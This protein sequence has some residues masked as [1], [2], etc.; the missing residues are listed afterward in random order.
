VEVSRL[1]VL[2]QRFSDRY[3][4]GTYD[5]GVQSGGRIAYVRLLGAIGVII[6]LV[7]AFNF[8]SLSTAMASRRMREVGM[9]KV[10]GARRGMIVGQFIG[11]AVLLATM[12]LV[13]SVG[14]VAVVLPF[15]NTLADKDLALTFRQETVLPFLGI[16]VFTGLLS[17]VY[18]AFFMSR[19]KPLQTLKN[20]LPLKAGGQWIRQGLVVTQFGVSVVLILFTLVVYGQFQLIQQR[21]LGFAKDNIIYFDMDGAV[22]EKRE[23]FLTELRKVPGVEMASALFTMGNG[24]L[25]QEQ[26]TNAINWAG[27][28]PDERMVMDYR[29]VDYD[30]MELLELELVE[31]RTF[32]PTQKSD[33]FE[34]VLNETAV[35][36]L[37]L[38]DPIGSIVEVWGKDK[39]VIGVVKDLHIESIQSHSADPMFFIYLNN[40]GFGAFNTVMAR[41]DEQQDL[42]V[43]LQAIQHLHGKFNPGFPIQ[44]KFLDHDVERLYEAEERLA[45]LT[46][47]FAGLAILISCLG[48]LGLVAFTAER[49]TKE[50]GIRKILGLSEWGIIR[51]IST[52]Y[53]RLVLVAVLVALPIGVLICRQWLEQFAFKVEISWWFM[54]MAGAASL[55]VAW[56]VASWQTLKIAKMNPTTSLRDE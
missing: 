4:Y 17:G 55:A 49:R 34:I 52:E 33:L 18:P 46:K 45:S 56:L 23:T 9:K 44:I 10:L 51:L 8:I 7:A 40:Y 24:F 6:L 35:E 41:L 16:T 54:L 38:T 15:F 37:G 50:I 36:Q 1:S 39:V 28:G 27:K 5:Q 11:E 48:L 20:K 43:T 21:Q 32:S 22:T 13:L 31:G 19:F 25:G 30:F 53:T 12:A 2:G 42:G 26:V 3:L 47:Y 29:I 14:L